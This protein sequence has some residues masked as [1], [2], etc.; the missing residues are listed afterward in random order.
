VN[1]VFFVNFVRAS[2]SLKF[3][4]VEREISH[5]AHREH[6]D[7]K[8]ERL[9]DFHNFPVGSFA[10]RSKREK[11]KAQSFW[12]FR[13]ANFSQMLCQAFSLESDCRGAALTAYFYSHIIAL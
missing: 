13:P 9:T 6:E 10:S 7:H 3:S 2:N 1:L 8:E 4:L 11:L 5:Q 12:S